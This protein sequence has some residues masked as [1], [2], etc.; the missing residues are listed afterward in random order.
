MAYLNPPFKFRAPAIVSEPVLFQRGLEKVPVKKVQ[1]TL[2]VKFKHIFLFFFLI[3]AIFVGLAKVYLILITCDDLAVKTTQVLSKHDF[4]ARDVQAMA[5]AS[6]L[7]NL[8]ALDI[9]RLK[10]RVE[11]HPWVKEARLRKVFP[12]QVRIEIR[13]REPAAVLRVGESLFVIAEDGVVLER[14]TA[15][16]DA[17]L[18]VLV[19]SGL[20]EDR[21]HDKLRLAWDCLKSLTAEERASVETLDVSRTD[22]VG[23]LFKGQSTRIILGR[24]RFSEKLREYWSN[25]DGW[26]SQNGALEYVD[27]RFDDR[28]YLKPLPTVQVAA[29]SKPKVEVE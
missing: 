19:D 27:L 15:R 26:E 7:G 11:S 28:V 5:D 16:E 25:K 20:F 8:L 22:S 6:K 3:A 21:Y 23:L 17:D 9:G 13:E 29:L 14:L 12:S 4:V 10:S 18:P 1:R 2:V 24:E